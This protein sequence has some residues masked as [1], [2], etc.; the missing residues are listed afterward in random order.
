METAYSPNARRA[1]LADRAARSTLDGFTFE[2]RCVVD[3]VS[4]AID[5]HHGIDCCVPVEPHVPAEA[6]T[7]AFGLPTAKSAPCA[8]GDFKLAVE[9]GSSVNCELVHFCA[10]G[11]GTHSEC[12]GHITHRRLALRNCGPRCEDLI[13]SIVLS[14]TPVKFGESG[15]TYPGSDPEAL[16]DDLVISRRNLQQAYDTLVDRLGS[17]IQA[18]CRGML[19][20]TNHAKTM[21]CSIFTDTNPPFF[22]K[23]AIEWV[24]NRNTEHIL[25]D[26][27]SVDREQC[28]PGLLAHS[29][30][31]GFSPSGGVDA[32]SDSKDDV[33]YA[34]RSTITELCHIPERAPD[35]TYMLA[36]HVSPFD[37]DAA[38]S[39]P[40][41]YPCCR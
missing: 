15:D 8:F 19:I 36:L 33:A 17:N 9:H 25:V 6:Q 5:F 23:E 28:G 22:T 31:F 32:K 3:N 34:C 41:L 13:P 11:S 20:R 10:H 4:W 40:I 30:F 21:K 12:V 35:G 27:P 24:C 16:V 39:R 26:L 37:M 14:V 18:F 38:P 29:T 7:Q 2:A 1:F